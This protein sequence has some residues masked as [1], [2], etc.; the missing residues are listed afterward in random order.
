MVTVRP[1]GY[2]ELPAVQVLFARLTAERV[3][4]T[5]PLIDDEEQRRFLLEM[6]NRV[7]QNHQG[8]F[9]LVAESGPGRLVGFITG[10][11]AERAIGKPRLFAFFEWLGVVEGARTLGI[12]RALANAALD[13]C[14]ARGV[15]HVECNGSSVTAPDWERRGFRPVFTREVSTVLACREAALPPAARPPV[16]ASAEKPVE[17]ETATRK[18]NRARK[19]K[20]RANGH[21]PEPTP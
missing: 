1:A 3:E 11:L 4:A 21:A 18:R 7:D 5:Y 2:P 9:C 16:G 13:W 6:A 19:V 17:K 14:V 8:A 12:G 10:Q 20:P 15:T